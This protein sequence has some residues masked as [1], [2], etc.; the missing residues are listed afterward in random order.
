M[1]ADGPFLGR[2]FARVSMRF[3]FGME[4]AGGYVRPDMGGGASGALYQ[5]ERRQ[6]LDLSA[7]DHLTCHPLQRVLTGTTHHRTMRHLDIGNRHLRQGVP[8][9]TRLSA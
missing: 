2:R 3:G 8:S 4:S 7:L 6:I 1:V 5:L 9:M